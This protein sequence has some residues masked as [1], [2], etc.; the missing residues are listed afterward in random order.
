MAK[1]EHVSKW[2]I[3]WKEYSIGKFVVLGKPIYELYRMGVLIERADQAEPLKKL[4]EKHRRAL[5]E[6][7][8]AR[9]PAP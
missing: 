9:T 1:W 3:V 4:A 5:D 6:S 8:G 7:S 2:G